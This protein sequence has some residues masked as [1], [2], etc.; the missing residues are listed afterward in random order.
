MGTTQRINNGPN[1]G[2]ISNSV[3]GVANAVN[4]LSALDIVDKPVD[5]KVKIDILSK[6]EKKL[7]K[8]KSE[9]VIAALD[10]LVK[11]GG[12]SKSIS[13]G[14]SNV[15]G[16]SGLKSSKK[17]ASF[18]LGVNN[19]GIDKALEQIGFSN[20]D[21]KTTKEIINYLIDYFGDEAIGMDEA[22]ANSAIYE[23]MK[24]LEN[25]VDDDVDSLE[26]IMKAYVD[27]TKL[28]EFL[29]VFFGKYIYEYLWERFEE[30]LKQKKGI[31]ITKETFK[32]I[33]NEIKSRV[34]LLNSNRK[35]SK[36]DW[37]GNEGKEEIEKIFEAI[38]KIEE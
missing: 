20:L 16:K 29:C 5:D 9:H 14:R 25:Q 24:E 11:I 27:S 18:F 8:R 23:V 36:I 17:I 31:D 22:A 13:T 1:W 28:S 19:F 15:I 7:E 35:L 38:I 2:G 10:R 32:S 21:G 30:K 34:Q 4:D 37:N 26:N 6:K 12:G 3:T 33:E